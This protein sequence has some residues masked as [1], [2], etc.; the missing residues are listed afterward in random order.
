MLEACEGDELTAVRALATAELASILARQGAFDRAHTLA[1]QAGTLARGCADLQA[2]YRSVSALGQT[3]LEGGDLNTA[4]EHIVAALDM[5]R[6][7]S[8]RR[9]EGFEL[10]Q[11]AVCLLHRSEF[12]AAEAHAREALAIFLEIRDLAS[13]G[14]CRVNLGRILN[15]MQRFEEG[16]ALLELGLAKTHNQ[17]LDEAR[18]DLRRASALF[19]EI[20]SLHLW[21]SEVA[22]AQL[23]L[24][25]ND[26]PKAATHARRA[27][28][29]VDILR[30]R[31]GH[32]LN[33]QAFGRSVADVRDVLDA[34][35]R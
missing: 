23:A 32:A 22:L 6:R 28:Q 1:L 12:Q 10:Q 29:L 20:D 17:E 4:H 13:E 35:M 34:V 25:E 14:D 5:A 3:H 11:L 33:T 27:S 19:S 7:L 24:A 21:R 15:A 9:R 8:L 31:L 2:E 18:E 26:R 16:I 30:S